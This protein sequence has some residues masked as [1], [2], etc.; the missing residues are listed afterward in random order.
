MNYE[1]TMPTFENETHK[2]TELCRCD[3]SV[4]K[5]ITYNIEE[6]TMKKIYRKINEILNG[7]EIY[8]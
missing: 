4:L 2:T 3:Y 5:R 8:G 7:G 1:D 6:E